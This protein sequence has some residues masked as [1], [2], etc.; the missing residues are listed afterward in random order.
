MTQ[1]EWIEQQRKLLDPQKQANLA[2]SAG[3]YDAQ[4]QNTQALYK[5]QIADT[6]ASYEDALRSNE[7]QKFLNQRAIERRKSRAGIRIANAAP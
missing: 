5:G 2:A 3:I 6:T 7:T 1:Q 4:R